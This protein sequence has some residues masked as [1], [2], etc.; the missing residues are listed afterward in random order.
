MYLAEA[1]LAD[2]EMVTSYDQLSAKP[3]TTAAAKPSAFETIATSIITGAAD[4]YK[5]K[6]GSKVDAGTKA[7]QERVAAAQRAAAEAS[8]RALRLSQQQAGGVG[9]GTVVAIVVGGI[10]VVGLGVLAWM[11]MQKKANGKT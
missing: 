10:A 2:G 3:T 4:I 8:E 11:M 5:A 6:I 9:T 1:E 7:A